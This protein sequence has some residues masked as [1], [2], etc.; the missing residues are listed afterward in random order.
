MEEQGQDTNPRDQPLLDTG[1]GGGTEG[2]ASNKIIIGDEETETT[3]SLINGGVE[4]E[5]Y[6]VDRVGGK[7]PDKGLII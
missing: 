4:R 1:C 6:P 7:Q 2:A 3:D 5:N